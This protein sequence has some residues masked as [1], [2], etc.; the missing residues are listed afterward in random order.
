MSA[1]HGKKY[2]DMTHIHTPTPVLAVLENVTGDAVLHA[3][4]AAVRVARVVADRVHQAVVVHV[5]KVVLVIV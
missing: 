4:A 3:L 5:P 2:T 1:V